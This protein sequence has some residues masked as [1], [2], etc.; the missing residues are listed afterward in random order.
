MDDKAICRLV[1]AQDKDEIAKI[2]HAY[3][4]KYGVE[5]PLF[6]KCDVNGPTAHPLFAFLK[7]ATQGQAVPVPVW[8]KGLAPDDVQWNFTKW[9]VVD[10]TPT[11]RYSWDA[12]PEAID[13]DVAAALASS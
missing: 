3:E 1:G 11:K 4:E 6:A 2:A 8:N 12:K 10:G 13:A 7:D 5:F 9:L